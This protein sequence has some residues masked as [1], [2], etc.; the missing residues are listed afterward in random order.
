[1]QSVFPTVQNQSKNTNAPLN[2]GSVSKNTSKNNATSNIVTTSSD[3]NPTN[4]TNQPLPSNSQNSTPVNTASSTQTAVSTNTNS[5]APLQSN[6]LPSNQ[7]AYQPMNNW[8]DPGYNSW[9]DPYWGGGTGG[10]GY[11]ANQNN[12]E[13]KL[14]PEEREEMIKKVY[15]YVLGRDATVRDI[16]Y[17]KYSTLGEKDIAK[18]LLDSQEHKDILNN[19][20]EYIDLKSNFDKTEDKN[21]KME[22]Q[23]K[24]Q[25]EE[26]KKLLQ[27][28]NEK[29]KY[30]EQL[31]RQLNNPYN[32]VK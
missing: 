14:T 25:I 19:A 23:I 30:I 5:S 13:K 10:F 21:K 2:N 27:L 9:N 18:Q 32:I 28:L 11:G 3:A 1:M 4:S 26:F 24:D 29:N 15:Q 8:S 20:R 7:P 22:T 6:T 31:R 17:Y 12:T 16:N